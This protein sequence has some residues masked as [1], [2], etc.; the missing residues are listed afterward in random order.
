MKVL[1]I[2][3][4]DTAGGAAIAAFRLHKAMLEAGIDSRFFCLNRII[5]DDE[6]ILTVSKKTK[7]LSRTLDLAKQVAFRK[8]R[9]SSKKGLFSN[10]FQGHKISKEINISQYDVIYIHWVNGSFLSFNALAEILKTE[11][12]TY[13][14]MHDMFPITGG[15]HYSFE[16]K[17]YEKKCGSCSYLK[18]KNKKD[19]SFKQLNKKKKLLKK[20]KNLSFVAPSR[21][22]YECAKASA[23]SKECGIR[24]F[25]VPN[26][27]N[28]KTFKPMDKYFCRNALNIPQD[29][30][31]ILFGADGALVN[32]Y[33]GFDYLEKALAILNKN[34]K[35]NNED[36]L[37]V[38]FGSSYN[39]RIEK[40]LPFKTKF[41][42]Y[43]HDSATL[44]L[45]Y[46]ASDVFCIPSLAENFANTI[47]E[48]VFCKT[49]VVGFNVGGIPDVVNN[50]TGYLA[51]YKNSADFAEGISKILLGE[52]NPNFVNINQYEA[53]KVVE[54]HKMMW[55]NNGGGYSRRVISVQSSLR[56][57]A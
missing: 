55:K 17:E 24:V 2:N 19:F 16:C 15:C 35:I 56:E 30:K 12:Q 25:H 14:F 10:F 49:P 46:N 26:L 8:N 54:R 3:T 41:T 5:N 57:A 39:S 51:E 11:K 36:I 40:C 38:I 43:L 47:L 42:G 32:P 31:V 48:S 37:L 28:S 9:L 20:Y 27:L 33:K 50:E 1:H 18:N 29:K 4:S 13:W 44:N 52:I 34:Q 45:L 23:I 22:L 53:C 7:I 6:R 21:W